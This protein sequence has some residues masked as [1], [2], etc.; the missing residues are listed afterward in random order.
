VAGNVDN[1][2]VE[3]AALLAGV[4]EGKDGLLVLTNDKIASLNAAGRHI[5]FFTE[6]STVTV[7][8]E[9]PNHEALAAF[10][11]EA[12]ARSNA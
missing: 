8:T 7:V 6:D 3:G 5:G 1:L 9:N 4:R 11:Q 12:L 10:Y 2:S